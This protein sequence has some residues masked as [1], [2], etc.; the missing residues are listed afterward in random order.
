MEKSLTDYKEIFSDTF[1][2]RHKV[3]T[4]DEKH[5]FHIH[6]ELELFLVLSEH[7]KC[8]VNDKTYLVK[9][10]TLLIFNS[11]DL[12]YVSM[13]QPGVNDRYVVFFK[14]EYIEFLSSGETNLLECFLFRPFEDANVLP[15]TEHQADSLIL[16]MNRIS[17]INALPPGSLYGSDL[18]VK[19]YLAELLLKV[20]GIYRDYHKVGDI[21]TH[22]NQ[23]LIYNVIN[24]IH[25]NYWAEL[26]LDKL[27]A[28]FLINKFYLCSLFKEVTGTTITQYLISCRM[29]RAKEFLMRGCS[30]DETCRQVGYN[31]LA[32]FSREFKRKYG[33]GP[34]QYQML[35]RQDGNEASS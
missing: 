32:H 13:T 29:T 8:V 9:P 23:G 10:N 14:P 31:S 7:I 33:M 25:Q 21:I 30:V 19:L 20:N 34:K 17:N 11:M 22:K 6:D 3:T 2:L 28:R 18:Y 26:S 16:L 27:A 5:T 4:I 15:L 35:C 1:S 12:H 24:Y